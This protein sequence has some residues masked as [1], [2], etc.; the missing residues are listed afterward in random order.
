[1]KGSTMKDTLRILGSLRIAPLAQPAP[2]G[3]AR[4]SLWLLGWHEFPRGFFRFLLFVTAWVSSAAGGDI[5][6]KPNHAA[7]KFDGMEIIEVVSDT[8]RLRASRP[9][10]A[11]IVVKSDEP[12]TV[13]AA[14]N[15]TARLAPAWD[16]TIGY[17]HYR[18]LVATPAAGEAAIRLRATPPPPAP[19]ATTAEEIE[20]FKRRLQTRPSRFPDDPEPFREWQSQG[21]AKLAALLMHGGLPQRVPLEAKVLEKQELPD[22]TLQRVEY[23]SQRD[24]K[25][26]LLLSLP[27]DAVNAP[28]LLALH[29]HEAS[30][31]EA[32][33]KAYEPGHPDD[34]MSFF[35]RRGW[36][37]LQPATMN[38]TL[39]LEGWTL[40]GEWTW[41]AMVAL[42]YAATLPEIDMDSVAVCGLSTGGH[43]AMNMLA[44]DERVKAG[45]TGC[46]L[47]T[48]NHYQRRF[49]LP[50]HCD[51][52]ISFQLAAD[53]E[54]CDWAALAAPKRV[55]FQ[56]GRQDA[57]LCPGAD[58]ARLDLKWNTGVMPQAEYD[59]LFSEVRRA[60]RVLGSEHAVATSIHDGQHKVDSE[61]AFDWLAPLSGH[62]SEVQ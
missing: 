61:R 14:T 58:E 1:M 4:D 19:V 54:Q 28:L 53:F 11:C 5:E 31:G 10:S 56:H 40:Q 57:A 32:D 62:P 21:R 45:V 52:G 38:H 30:W 42:D 23:R 16:G 37:V 12:L 41:D 60:Y 59:A 48:W 2:R 34:F 51:C 43:L 9:A 18:L 36:A 29:G 6:V 17:C 20:E 39:Q 15:A 24:R 22:F 50:P 25:N 13:A 47:S 46:I 33:L 3:T 35:A 49:R 27:R 7:T 55:Q 44:L 26:V 8:V